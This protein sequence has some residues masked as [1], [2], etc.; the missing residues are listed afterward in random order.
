MNDT[1]KHAAIELE[2]VHLK[3]LLGRSFPSDDLI[4]YLSYNSK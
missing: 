3:S 2:S 4:V 1:L